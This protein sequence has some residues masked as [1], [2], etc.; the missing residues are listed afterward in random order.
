MSGGAIPEVLSDAQIRGQ[1]E[2]MR[3]EHGLAGGRILVII[4]DQT[5]TA[6][7][8]RFFRLLHEA[9]APAAR[10]LDFLVALGTHPLLK[11]EEKLRRVGI[12]RA[13]KET[14][15]GRTR[16]FNH[17]WDRPGTFRGI[18]RIDEREME[19]LTGGLLREGVE[20][21]INR[22]IFDYDRLL[23]LG[24]VYPHEIAGFSGSG[25]YFFPG[26]GGPDFIDATHWLGALQTNL[27][28]IGIRDTPVR[29]LIDRAARM[30]PVPVVYLNLVVDE[31]E[32]KG[33]F[34]G[35]ERS[36]WEKAVELSS[37]LNIRY[38][39]RPLRSVLSIPSTKYEDFWTGAKAVYKVEPIVADG[40][41][42][43]VYAP[44]IRRISLTHDRMLR[45]MGF[46]LRDYFL[47]HP[48]RCNGLRRAVLA[49][50][51]LVK[52]AGVYRDGREE[53]RVRVVLASGVPQ[54]LCREL[55]LDSLDPREIRVEEWENRQAEGIALVRNAGEVLYRVGPGP[56]SGR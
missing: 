10:R 17:R 42:L 9:C 14:L 35:P 41:E 8:D 20:I 50:S 36:A 6:P 1:L 5:R 48:D 52:G 4:P 43:I 45:R 2:R 55:N 39:E 23:V 37:R 51:T 56:A 29:R 15:Y 34:I 53:P 54:S 3:E 49:Y 25:K 26:I 13:E 46:H 24:P 22:R 40:G 21:Q 11:Q 31:G 30:I 47:A 44:Q 32:L 7:V 38:V 16:I 28:T 27:E 19:Q 18:G 33:L 12:S